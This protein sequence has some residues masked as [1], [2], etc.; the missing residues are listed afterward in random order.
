VAVRIATEIRLKRQGC[1]ASHS[2][3]HNTEAKKYGGVSPHSELLYGVAILEES[4]NF[5][6]RRDVS[7]V[8]TFC[9]EIVNG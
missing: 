1:E 9:N 6:V 8:F 7:L 2:F 5:I 3:L 4:G